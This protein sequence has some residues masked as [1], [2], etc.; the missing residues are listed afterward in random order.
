LKLVVGYK[1]L[2]NIVLT[3]CVQQLLDTI[4]HLEKENRTLRDL[5]LSSCAG[6]VLSAEG[7]SEAVRKDKEK[8]VKEVKLL[9]RTIEE[10]ELRIETQKQTLATRD[11]SIRKLM[12][13]LQARGKHI[14]LNTC[15]DSV[16]QLLF[17]KKVSNVI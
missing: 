7:D 8:Q 11:E 9:K 2:N 10:M 6:L 13:M 12:D 4:K 16:T 5:S 1:K 15:S 17:I 3:F 14:Y